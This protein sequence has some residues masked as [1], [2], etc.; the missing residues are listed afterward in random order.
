MGAVRAVHGTGRWGLLVLVM[1]VVGLACGE[2]EPGPSGATDGSSTG[3]TSGTGVDTSAGEGAETTWMLPDVGPPTPHQTLSCSTWVAC[4]TELGVEGLAEI[5]AA[6]GIAGTCWDGDGAQAA[7]CDEECTGQLE[8]TVMELETM[9]QVVPEACDP[10]RTV[11]WA[12]I[13]AIITANCVEACHEPGGEDSSLDMSSGAYYAIYGV[14]SSQSSLSLVAAG[15]HEDSYFWHKVSGS[16]G[17]VSGSGS[18]M[19]KGAPMLTAE[20]I[21]AIADWIDGGA[22]PF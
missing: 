22:Q 3:A 16:Q 2:P 21:D 6:Y 13:E 4:A 19:P 14:A 10:P 15:S 1:L 12:E 11:S 18:T 9:G 5:E 17:S 8:A 20:E 7:A